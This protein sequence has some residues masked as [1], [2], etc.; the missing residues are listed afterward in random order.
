[1]QLLEDG[2]LEIVGG[3]GWS[4]PDAVVGLRFP[5]P[6]NNPNTHVVLEK[7]PLIIDDT[8]KGYDSF[9]QSLH[10]HI[11]SWLGVPLIVRSRVIGM[12]AVDGIHSSHFTS[13]H[14]H[15]VTAFADQVAIA[16]E[17]ARLFEQTQ[18][19][20]AE[21]QMLYQTTRS[22]I[23]TVSL[24]DLLQGL[25]DSLAGSLPADR[26]VLATVDLKAQEVLHFIRGGSGAANVISIDFD[27]IW[28]GLSGWVM[29][30][31]KPALSPKG[32]P[33]IR[34]SQAAR[35]RRDDT[36]SGSTIVV[37]L[38]Y[39]NKVL[40]A[41]TA[42]NRP[43]Q[44]DFVQRDVALMEAIAHQA[45]IVIE[46][47]RLFEEVQRL[48]TTDELMGI[49][50]RRHFFQLGQVE[51]ERAR[52]YHSPLSVMML[53]VD[54][55]KEINDTYGHAIGDQVLCSL[56]QGCQENI[57]EVDILG[58]YGGEEFAIILPETDGLD[59]LAIAERLR[60]YVQTVPRETQKGEV[61]V[62]ISVGVAEL[63][64]NIF[65]LA[66]LLDRADSALYAAKQAG[67][68]CVK[69]YE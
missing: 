40:G 21:T 30:E 15:L 4:N 2:Y 56:A 31:L 24:P 29:R 62:T 33:D 1:V 35:K 59:A 61:L 50:N 36:H 9:S 7:R 6:G 5:V 60:K 22:L 42:I 53:D 54:H 44:R 45:A 34:E 16:I 41:M 65:D 43:D 8:S 38:L 23:D 63:T 51:I 68:N 25:V 11:R 10:A 28:Q 14:V 27:E 37:P 58:R 67:R 13:D 48:A 19:A 18:S 55:F 39:R 66:S 69:S 3:R 57:R 64:E 20:L 47:A 12:L 32:R 17:N 49:H 46:N 52:R 26:V